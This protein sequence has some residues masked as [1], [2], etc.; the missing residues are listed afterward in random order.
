MGSIGPKA[1]V[2]RAMV[3]FLVALSISFSIFSFELRAAEQCPQSFSFSE[4]DWTQRLTPPALSLFEAILVH[5]NEYPITDF[6]KDLGLKNLDVGAL[7]DL[8]RAL[9]DEAISRNELLSLVEEI[10]SKIRSYQKFVP[11]QVV[12]L[13][14]DPT[15]MKEFKYFRAVFKQMRFAVVIYS[16]E[17][18]YPRNFDAFVK[19]MG[20][21]QDALKMRDLKTASIATRKLRTLLKKKEWKQIEAEIIGFKKTS[22]TS[23]NQFIE[24]DLKKLAQFTSRYQLTAEAFHESR[25]VVSRLVALY[26]SINVVQPNAQT[27]SIIQILSTFNGKMGRAHDEMVLKS[28]RGEID[29]EHTVLDLPRSLVVDVHNFSTWAL[30]QLK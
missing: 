20:K 18:L 13:T 3:R 9:F 21:L 27:R 29:Y 26:D 4:Q 12:P 24:Q 5:D 25:K 22:R 8:N 30:R 16:K 2:F 28:A 10:D 17:H 15:L 23:L 7:I 14:L 1:A 6:P 11:N 19:V